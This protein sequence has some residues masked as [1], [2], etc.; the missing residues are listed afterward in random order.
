M[1]DLLDKQNV[2]YKLQKAIL[3]RLMKFEGTR[4]RQLLASEDLGN[5]RAT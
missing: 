3:Y 1:R 5:R 2:Y 4:L